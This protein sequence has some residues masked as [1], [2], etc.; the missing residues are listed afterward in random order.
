MANIIF[1]N[2]CNISCPFCFATE[3]NEANKQSNDKFNISKAWSISTFINSKNFRFCGG[4]PTLN[5]EIKE[6]MDSLL[7]GGYKLFFMT[8]GIWPSE[9]K[10]YYA[11]LH[12]SQ[13][14][15]ISFLFNVLP[16]ELYS[17]N[18]LSILNSTL[19]D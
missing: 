5:P 6:T 13:K 10:S 17:Q 12:D 18:Q 7:N 4:E 15:N 8:N 3:N 11:S 16:P 2:K 19:T 1:T 9:F 14:L